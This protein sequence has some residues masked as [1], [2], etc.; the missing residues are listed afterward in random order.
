MVDVEGVRWSRLWVGAK[1]GKEIEAG[2]E[3]PVM[4]EMTFENVSTS[5]A[6][7]LVILLFEDADHNALDRVELDPFKARDGRVTEERQKLK[8]DGDVLL[9]AEGVYVYMEVRR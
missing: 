4:V 6:D 3:V 8:L 7:L 9:A 1:E 2:K 5:S